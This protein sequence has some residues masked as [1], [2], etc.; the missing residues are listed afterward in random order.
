MVFGRIGRK[1]PEHFIGEAAPSRAASSG[2]RRQAYFG[3][4]QVIQRV[5][6]HPVAIA[7]VGTLALRI[8]S[9]FFRKKRMVD[10]RAQLG[11][12]AARHALMVDSRRVHAWN[13]VQSSSST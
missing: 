12:G 7:R 3:A 10:G 1:F 4:N 13:R 11:T 6:A 9:A 2:R 8:R 5:I